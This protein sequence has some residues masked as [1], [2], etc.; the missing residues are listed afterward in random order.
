MSRRAREAAAV[1]LAAAAAGCVDVEQRLA[2]DGESIAAETVVVWRTG[3]MAMAGA[4]GG[5]EP[6]GPE[7]LCGRPGEPGLGG[8]GGGG[9][10]TDP[11]MRHLAG[12]QKSQQEAAVTLGVHLAEVDED[13]ATQRI[14]CTYRMPAQAIAEVAGKGTDF[15]LLYGALEPAQDGWRMRVET[16]AAAARKVDAAALG[17]MMEE[18]LPEGVRR[19]APGTPA[20]AWSDAEGPCVAEEAEA[21]DARELA[22]IEE[23]IREMEA[24]GGGILDALWESVG[25]SIRIAGRMAPEPG[26][27]WVELKVEGGG[28]EWRGRITDAWRIGPTVRIEAPQG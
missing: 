24:L 28:W 1:A 21:A 7:E 2:S 10:V 15:A 5:T 9:A 22:G 20:D 6:P 8:L 14:R 23:A 17:A 19:C 27:G 12:T 11:A 18:G 4:L 3:M 16:G 26:Q 13:E 25:L